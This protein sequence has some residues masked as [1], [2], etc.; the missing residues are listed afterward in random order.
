MTYIPF[1]T[2]C[3]DAAVEL[4][5]DYATSASVKLQTYRARPASVNPP[6]AFVD[7]I[8]ENIVYPAALGLRQ[9]NLSVHVVILWGLF[10]SGTAVDQ[11]DLFVDGFLDWVTARTDAADPNATIAV[12]D[13]EDDPS[14]VNDWMKPE[15][16]R[17][18]YATRFTLEGFVGG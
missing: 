4:L 17:T 7:R 2:S 6:C 9:R 11:R 10:D 8:S 14:F 1:S 16:Q 5:K 18:Y 13:V 15:T 12:S 3:R